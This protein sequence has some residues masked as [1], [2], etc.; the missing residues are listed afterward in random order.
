MDFCVN[1]NFGQSSKATVKCALFHVIRQHSGDCK[2]VWW[3]Y[4][5]AWIYLKLNLVLVM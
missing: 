4:R 2:M 3:S 5:T 1:N